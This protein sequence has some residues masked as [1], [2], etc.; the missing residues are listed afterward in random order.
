[1]EKYR[2]NVCVVITDPEREQVLV[3]RRVDV[4]LGPHRWQFP[5]GG[6]NPAES[7]E[8]GMRRELAE[9]I[10]TG[11]VEILNRTRNPLRYTYPPDVMAKLENEGFEKGRF[12]GQEQHWFLA[13]LPM[14]TE[15]IHFNNHIAE[16]DGWEWVTPAEAVARVV[17]FKQEV[18]QLAL[19][20]FGL[21]SADSPE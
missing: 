9:E 11:R 18:Y 16:F 2:P 21:L 19:T 20:E 1:M 17:P 15:A 8:E 14:G 10:G 6:L 4:A 3:F 12:I 5:Q 13:L 7:P